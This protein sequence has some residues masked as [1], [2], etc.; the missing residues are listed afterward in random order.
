M[1]V[2][3]VIYYTGFHPYTLRPVYTAKSQK[4][5]SNQH[6]FFFWYKRENYQKI[7]DKLTNMGRKDLVEK[8]ITDRKKAYK[9]EIIKA[10]TKL[11]PNSKKNRNRK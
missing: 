1:T 4:E 8:L 3:T 6:L 10:K 9:H 7:K 2:A 11:N 5:K